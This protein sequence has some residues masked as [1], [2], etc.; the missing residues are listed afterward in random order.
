MTWTDTFKLGA[1]RL[2]AAYI[3][4]V[5]E[6]RGQWRLTN[7]AVRWAP[8]LKGLKM[9]IA[10]RLRDGSRLLVDGT[11]Q[12]GRIAFVTGAYEPRTAALIC[13]S[14]RA[15]DTAVD[16]GANIGFFSI[17]AARVVGASGRVHAFEPVPGVRISLVDNLR[18]NDVSSIVVL[19]D[20]ALGAASGRVSF[21]LGPAADTG[22]GSLRELP[23]GTTIE[24]SQRR[25]DDI[26]ERRGR[27]ALV[28]IDVEG[29]ELGVLQGMDECLRRDHPRIVLEVTDQYLRACGASAEQLHEHLSARGYHMWF[30]TENGPLLPIGTAAAMQ[31]CPAQFNAFCSTDPADPLAAQGGR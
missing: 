3:R 28:K 18:L 22:L 27:V 26:F 16:V 19:H 8:L 4:N 12:T 7:V 11:S 30:I 5:P 1:L 2:L 31:S 13:A 23:N 24:V 6:H 14:L 29:G 9:P 25:F 15:G 17:V 21:Y 20:E 10:I